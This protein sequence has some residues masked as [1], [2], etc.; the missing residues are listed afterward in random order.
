[1]PLVVRRSPSQ[2][3]DLVLSGAFSG[4]LADNLLDF[5]G[6]VIAT[7]RG[8][9]PVVGLLEISLPLRTL[10]LDFARW[11]SDPD[12]S[13]PRCIVAVLRQT[14]TYE[15]GGESPH[16]GR[17][18]AGDAGAVPAPIDG[19]DLGGV[20]IPEV[21]ESIDELTATSRSAGWSRVPGV[22]D[23]V[24]RW[25]GRLPS[26]SGWVSVAVRVLEATWPCECRCSERLL[27][28]P[29]PVGTQFK[30]KFHRLPDRTVL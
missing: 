4:A 3:A 28:A 16:I 30:I 8:V 1:M 14:I 17:R 12:P 18:T 5:P 24:H 27:S 13:V 20:P 6:A 7:T 21:V 11:E 26:K 22:R 29:G 19:L 10:R 15:A 2:P 25:D 9:A 23:I